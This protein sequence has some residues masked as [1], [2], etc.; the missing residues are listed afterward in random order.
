MAVVFLNFFFLMM[1]ASPTYLH[2]PSKTHI[3]KKPLLRICL[4][5]DTM[6]KKGGGD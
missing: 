2:A 1:G 4:V 3:G 6:W 5:K